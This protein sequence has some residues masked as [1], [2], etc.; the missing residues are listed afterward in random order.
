MDI[1]HGIALFAKSTEA[2]AGFFRKPGG[3]FSGLCSKRHDPGI[4]P[5]GRLTRYRVETSAKSLSL[6]TLFGIFSSSCL[7]AALAPARSFF[8]NGNGALPSSIRRSIPE[9]NDCLHIYFD[10]CDR[11]IHESDCLIIQTFFI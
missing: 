11:I 6:P 10:R 8:L 7:F 5:K 2:A 4:C 3:F 9:K 1:N